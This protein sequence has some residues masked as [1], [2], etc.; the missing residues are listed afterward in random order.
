MFLVSVLTVL[1][2]VC[3]FI[4]LISSG[5]NSIKEGLTNNSLDDFIKFLLVVYG[6]FSIIA[7]I[8][9]PLHWFGIIP[10]LGD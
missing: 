10:P 4:A 3:V 2:Y 6:F 1:C 7:V 8:L 9:L 5:L